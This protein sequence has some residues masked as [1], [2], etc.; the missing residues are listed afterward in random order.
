MRGF[1]PR[2]FAVLLLAS[3]EA[4]LWPGTPKGVIGFLTTPAGLATSMLVTLLVGSFVEEMGSLARIRAGI[5]IRLFGVVLALA[6]IAWTLA[7][8]SGSTFG[9]V[10]LAVGLSVITYF[11]GNDLARIRDTRYGE[12]IRFESI[13]AKAIELSVERERDPDARRERD[14][15]RI[16]WHA[17]AGVRIERYTDGRAI[18]LLVS[19]RDLVQGAKVPFLMSTRDDDVLFLTEHQCNEDAVDLAARI[20]KKIAS[21]GYR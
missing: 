5:G 12:P 16:P 21:E 7:F 15:L 18:A 14:H 4:I 3:G 2:A 6:S 10:M 11:A 9:W 13:D 20:R 19:R 1:L 8:Q 17:I